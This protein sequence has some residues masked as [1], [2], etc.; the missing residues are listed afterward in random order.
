MSDEK[1]LLEAQQAVLGSML[2]DEKT[3]GPVLQ[4]V[5]P[6]DFTTG[7]YRQIF[8]A[9]RAQFASGAACDPVTV[10]AR[11]GG[12]YDRLLMELIEITPTSANV[13]SYVAILKQEARI[14]RLQDVAQRM[15]EAED[16]DALRALMS[17]ANALSVERPGLRVVS[18][19]DALSKFYVRHDPDAKPVYLDFG[20]DDINDNVYAGRGDMIVIGGYPSDGKTS[21][22]LTLAVRMAKT[23]RVGF[24][25][26][27]TDADKLFDRIVAMTAQI[28]L[29]K[30]KLNAM[31]GNDWDAVAEVSARLGAVKLE[32]VEASGMTVQ[33][34]RAHSL[35]KR[36]DVI[37]IDYLQKIKSDITGRAS[38][39]QFQVVSKISSDLQQFGRQTGTPVIALSQLSR[40][41]KTKATKA[42]KIPPPTLSALRSSG[43]IE[44]DAD[45]VMLLYREEPDNSRSRRILNIAKNKEGE[46]NIALM[47]T[48]DGQTQTFRKSAAQ[49]PLPPQDKRWQPCNDDIPEQ[50][51]LPG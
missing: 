39:D 20:M 32:L 49:A 3:V 19:E 8:L 23:Q 16:E 17:E 30:L 15:L 29:P 12:K 2:I 22:A 10:N 6:D 47:L 13:K 7:A 36:Y 5:T 40:P 46:A 9:F 41:E 27:E 11:L 45:V 50:F 14:H 44:Q 31:N 35:S 34:I 25:S 1:K 21:L 37:F 38:A 43:Q 48:F 42:G 26:Y 24:Y 4:D 18:M 33:D 51:K 28:G